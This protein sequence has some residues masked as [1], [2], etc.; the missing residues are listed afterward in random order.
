MKTLKHGL[1][2]LLATPEHAQDWDTQLPRIL[3]GYRCGIQAS[4]RFSSHMVL[5]RRTPKLR[6]DNFESIGANFW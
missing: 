4:I 5:I 3:F 6:V 1:I 2:V